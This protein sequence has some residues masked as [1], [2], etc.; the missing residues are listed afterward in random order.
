MLLLL[1]NTVVLLEFLL[2]NARLVFLD[3]IFSILIFFNKTI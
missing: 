1:S 3:V 2:R